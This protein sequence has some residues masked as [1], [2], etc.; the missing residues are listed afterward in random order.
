MRT[1]LLSRHRSGRRKPFHPSSTN[2]PVSEAIEKMQPE[3]QKRVH[4]EWSDEKIE[5]SKQKCSL[6]RLHGEDTFQIRVLF[7][8]SLTCF[9]PAATNN[10]EMF[11]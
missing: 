1:E 9:I 3:K 7:V 11:F 5:D 2:A 8:V 10:S 4:P 6:K